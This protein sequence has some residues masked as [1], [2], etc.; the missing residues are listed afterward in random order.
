MRAKPRHP[1]SWSLPRPQ[2]LP[3]HGHHLSRLYAFVSPFRAEGWGLPLLEAMARGVP[4]IA[5]GYS[6]PTD[7][8]G[9]EA[10]ASITAVLIETPYFNRADG[11]YGQWAL[12]DRDLRAIT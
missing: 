11:D 3:S 9:A 8:L 5:T 7:F 1:I 12:P 2:I 6:A 10:F 4:V